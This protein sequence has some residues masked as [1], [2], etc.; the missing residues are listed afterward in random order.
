MK[1]TRISSIPCCCI[2]IEN[3]KGIE[4]NTGGF[5][6]GMQEFH[7]CTKALKRYRELGGEILTV[8]S[9]SHETILLQMGSKSRRSAEG[10]WIPVLYH[11]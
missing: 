3:G 7:P 11:L 5:K 4:L 10:M 8:G 6:K 1:N 2:V 9:D